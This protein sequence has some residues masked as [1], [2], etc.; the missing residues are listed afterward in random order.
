MSMMDGS[1][2]S[3]I[4]P[5]SSNTA[6]SALPRGTSPVGGLSRLPPT[7]GGLSRRGERDQRFPNPRARD[8]T[9]AARVAISGLWAKRLGSAEA[10]PAA[11]GGA[12]GAAPGAASSPNRAPA[13]GTGS[14]SSSSEP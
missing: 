11:P 6:L 3:A 4:A 13:G 2:S 12:S 1:S 14:S 8:T 9:D 7:T 5:S 10:I